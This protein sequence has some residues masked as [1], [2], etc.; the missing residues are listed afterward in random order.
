MDYTE[1]GVIGVF[2]LLVIDKLVTHISAKKNGLDPRHLGCRLTE[3]DAFHRQMDQ[4]V[5]RLEHVL[6]KIT[7]RLNQR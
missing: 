2:A 1:V 5:K 3:I 6:E 7:D 4:A